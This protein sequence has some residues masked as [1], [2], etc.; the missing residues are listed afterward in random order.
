[1]NGTNILVSNF[2]LPASKSSTGEDIFGLKLGKKFLQNTITLEGGR[3]V[4]VVE[5]T[6]VGRDNLIGRLDHLGVDK[7]L[8]RVLQEI[9]LVNR[10]HG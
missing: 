3:R 6:V 7:T 4:T 2:I 10:L 9:G 5:A 1:M 8:D